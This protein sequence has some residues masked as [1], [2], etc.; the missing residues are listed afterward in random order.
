MPCVVLCAV[1]VC[2]IM[3]LSAGHKDVVWQCSQPEYMMSVR[4]VVVSTHSPCANDLLPLTLTTPVLSQVEHEHYNSE[5][6]CEC[7]TQTPN[8]KHPVL[9]HAYISPSCCLDQA[10]TLLSNPTPSF[11]FTPARAVS[12]HCR[13]VGCSASGRGGAVCVVMQNRRLQFP[14]R[15]RAGGPQRSRGHG[16]RGAP[17]LEA[18]AAL[19]V[20]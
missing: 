8:A 11:N 12:M 16:L 1:R 4:D 3:L 15:G 6:W 5:R 19:G 13:T 9:S 20:L 10:G 2:C 14:Q 7:A 18:A 17:W